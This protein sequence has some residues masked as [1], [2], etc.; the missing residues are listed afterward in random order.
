MAKVYSK[1]GLPFFKIDS[2]KSQPNFTGG[3][4]SK[5]GWFVKLNDNGNTF[6]I[7]RIADL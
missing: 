6:T 2:R 4:E 5:R 7:R 1:H 3:A